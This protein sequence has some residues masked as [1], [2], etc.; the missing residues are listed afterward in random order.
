VDASVDLLTDKHERLSFDTDRPDWWQSLDESHGGRMYRV[1]VPIVYD[2][3]VERVVR[4]DDCGALL[5]LT[6]EVGHDFADEGRIGCLIVAR[7]LEDGTYRAFVF[8][9]LYPKTV[10][11]LPR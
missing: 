3:G 6:G 10:Q 1:L 5:Y 4:V 8:H 11:S 9:S 2:N 7:P